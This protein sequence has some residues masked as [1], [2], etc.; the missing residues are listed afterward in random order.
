MLK[1]NSEPYNIINTQCPTMY[2][3]EAII[4][5]DDNS[6]EEEA[7][8]CAINAPLVTDDSSAKDWRAVS[9]KGTISQP[10]DNYLAMNEGN[11]HTMIFVSRV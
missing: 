4:Y 1:E 6:M 2:D 9:A 7:Y 8:K 3:L 11:T 5:V 10:E